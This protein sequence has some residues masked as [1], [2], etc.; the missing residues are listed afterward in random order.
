VVI[1]FTYFERGGAPPGR[2]YRLAEAALV[3]LFVFL[4]L[5]YGTAVFVNLRGG[6]P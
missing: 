6:G 1:Q 4:T 3:G 2:R 5:V